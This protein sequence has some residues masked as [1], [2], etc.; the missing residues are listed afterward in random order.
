M[1]KLFKDL[2]KAATDLINKEYTND[3][4]FEVKTNS[5]DGAT[6]TVNGAKAAKDGK[7]SGSVSGKFKIAAGDAS[8]TVTGKIATSGALTAEGTLEGI[9]DGLKITLNASAAGK[10]SGKFGV[11][12]CADAFAAH[13]DFDAYAASGAASVLFASNG[14]SVGGAADF[15]L[16]SGL[17]GGNFGFGYTASDFGVHGFYKAKADNL[18]K[19]VCTSNFIHTVNKECSIAAQHTHDIAA[20]TDSMSFGGS[21]KQDKQTTYKARINNNG[22]LNVAY[23]TAL[24]PGVT[25]TVS[26]EVNTLKL[27]KDS[28]KVGLNFVLSN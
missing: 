1:V 3:T 20:G 13:A 15:K 17:S 10:P 18:H 5:A 23:I 25:M 6:F 12:Y 11:E 19:G 22:I 28:H 7:A 8:T 26:G 14:F 24:Q 27:D 16:D 4:K 9:A 2:G 21:Y